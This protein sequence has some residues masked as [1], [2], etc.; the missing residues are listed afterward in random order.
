MKKWIK[1]SISALGF[2][3]LY[4]SVFAANQAGNDKILGSEN[5]KFLAYDVASTD[6]SLISNTQCQDLFPDSWA[7]G[8]VTWHKQSVID[9]QLAKLT[10]KRL[11]GE[12]KLV[13]LGYKMKPHPLIDVTRKG[14]M[15]FL[16]KGHT[17]KTPVTLNARFRQGAGGLQVYS[18]KSAYCKATVEVIEVLK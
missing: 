13:D 3:V 1:L 2:L 17:V 4:N 18:L 5:M 15:S 9:V 8:K 11:V 12:A 6:K 16:L 7:D 10:F 14:T